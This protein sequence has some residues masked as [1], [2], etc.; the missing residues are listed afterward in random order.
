MNGANRALRGTDDHPSLP[1]VSP[2]LASLFSDSV[3]AYELTGLC[4]EESLDPA[5]ASY[6]QNAAPKRRREFAAGRLCARASLEALGL[7]GVPLLAADDRSPRWPAAVVGSITHTDGFCGAVVATRERM[8]G[9]G[10]DAELRQCV[11][12]HLWP[13][14]CVEDELRWLRRLS[15]ARQRDMATVLFSAKE[16]FYKCQYGITRAWLDFGDVHISI[17]DDRFEVRPLKPIEGLDS[18][19]VG[20]FSGRFR[21]ESDLVLTGIALGPGMTAR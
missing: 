4:H 8:S 16:A 2:V 18:S 9:L 6:I 13:Q 3:V 5:E 21:L 12:C 1:R 15:P 19:R 14:I 7:Y 10:I 17:E 20:R 11:Q